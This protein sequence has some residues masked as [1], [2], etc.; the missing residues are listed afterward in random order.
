MVS[1][2]PASSP[3]GS[4]QGPTPLFDVIALHM[5]LSLGSLRAPCSAPRQIL[6]SIPK[7]SVQR[8][9]LKRSEILK[10]FYTQGPKLES[11]AGDTQLGAE[12]PYKTVHVE[13]PYSAITYD[14]ESQF[15]VGASSLTRDFALFD[16][17]GA[18]LGADG[19]RGL[20]CEVDVF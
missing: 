12:L 3:F 20:R 15:L 18:I 9:R 1:S 19:A 17:D 10:E 16:E 2:V 4:W 13:H 14:S 7:R 5:V 11:W 6:L 8:E